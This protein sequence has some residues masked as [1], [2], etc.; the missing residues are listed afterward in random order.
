M[1]PGADRAVIDAEKVRDYLLS[2]E[3]AIGRFKAPVFEALGFSGAEWPAL[4]LALHALAATSSA[5][6]VET[7]RF[8]QKYRLT[9]TLQGRSGRQAV[10]VTIWIRRAGEDF[11]RFVT[12]YPG[13]RP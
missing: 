9:G 8:G 6:L 12:A 4:Q 2:H 1:L 10:I 13:G 7:S 3:H 11:P 5:T